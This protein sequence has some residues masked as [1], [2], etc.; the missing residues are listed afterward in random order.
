[1][2]NGKQKGAAFEREICR[3]LSLW[4]SQGKS[5]DLFWRTAMSGGRATVLHRKGQ[6]IRQVGDICAVSPEGHPFTDEWFIELKH[7]RRLALDQFLIKN[8]GP[9]WNYWT[10]CCFEA[11]KHRRKPM[12][13]GK[14]NGWPIILMVQANQL[15]GPDILLTCNE[16]SVDIFRFADVLFCKPNFKAV[17]EN[18]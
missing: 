12:L 6:S 3:Q 11:V 4:I 16:P 7:V 15:C 5:S 2:V 8:T 10:K 1:M 17:E 9:L 18:K 13:I 14:Q